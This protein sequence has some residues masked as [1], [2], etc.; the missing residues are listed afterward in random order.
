[1]TN[2]NSDLWKGECMV[3]KHGK[4]AMLIRHENEE[5][6]IPYSQVHDDSTLYEYSQVNEEDELVIPYWL[7]AKQG[8]A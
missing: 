5:G 3:V 2:Y 8:W 1:M 7:A 4:K 6:W